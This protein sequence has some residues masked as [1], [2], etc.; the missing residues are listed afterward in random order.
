MQNRMAEVNTVFFIFVGIAKILQQ[1][2]DMCL[3]KTTRQTEKEQITMSSVTPNRFGITSREGQGTP[4]LFLHGS[5][6]PA[7]A[8]IEDW[9]AFTRAL[10]TDRP[11]IFLR[12]H[13][14]QPD[15][16]SFVRRT[17]NHSL[18]PEEIVSDSVDC[19][20]FLTTAL[21]ATEKGSRQPILVGYSSGAI[22]AT[23]LIC[24][25]PDLFGGAI[26]LRP[27]SPFA[28]QQPI[29]PF[30]LSRKPILLLSGNRDSRRSPSDGSALAQNLRNRGAI[31]TH[32]DLDT[33]HNWEQN[34][35]DA[36]LAK[37]WLDQLGS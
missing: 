28:K 31:V 36:T 15:G 26:L 21:P 8:W 4:L 27:Q 1:T 16:Y 35:Q 33:D 7:D 3:A 10:G 25:M 6:R 23:A 11:S 30:A 37:A 5:A 24:Q 17:S 9:Q 14:L 13:H 18:N 32:Y 19:V 12:G 29:D 34:G 2:G 20:T 22:F